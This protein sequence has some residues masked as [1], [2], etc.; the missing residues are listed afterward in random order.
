LASVIRIYHDAR[1]SECQIMY[2]ARSYKVK[3]RVDEVLIKIRD[4]VGTFQSPVEKHNN[5]LYLLYKV[6]SEEDWILFLIKTMAVYFLLQSLTLSD[7]TSS[8]L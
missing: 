3:L 1:Y 4:N 5:K 2:V 8:L 6:N 7:P